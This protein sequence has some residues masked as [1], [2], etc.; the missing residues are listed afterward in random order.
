MKGE[1]TEEGREREGGKEGKVRRK[2][3]KGV[4][5]GESINTRV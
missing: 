1:E 2:E 5:E 3:G 4:W